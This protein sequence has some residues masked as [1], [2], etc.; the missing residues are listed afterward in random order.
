MIR[1]S[2][3]IERLCCAMLDER[4]LLRAR[5]VVLFLIGAA[6]VGCALGHLAA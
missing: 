3:P 1:P 4:G 2:S 6:L 5:F